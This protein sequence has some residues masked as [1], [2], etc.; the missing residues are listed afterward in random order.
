[1]SQTDS[2][3][4]SD[5]TVVESSQHGSG[6]AD[7]V[8]LN[9]QTNADSEILR[10]SDRTT[11][12]SL[13]ARENR[14]VELNASLIKRLSD[15]S[16]STDAIL[17]SIQNLDT[18]DKIAEQG[19]VLDRGYND[20]VQLYDE[21]VEV[22]ENKVDASIET[23]STEY[24]TEVEFVKAELAKK[25]EELVILQEEEENA[26]RQL[27]AAKKEYAEQ[28]RLYEE[29]RRRRLERRQS[30]KY[31]PDQQS[32]TGSSP[33]PPISPTP[34][35]NITLAQ[36]AVSPELPT[37]SACPASSMSVRSYDETNVEVVKAI[38]EN[39]ATT[40]SKIRP[41]KSVKPDVFSGNELE[42]LHWEID[43]EAYLKAEDIEGHERLRHLK[44]FTEGEAR[45]CIE[46]YFS[47]NSNKAYLDARAKLKSRYGNKQNVARSF[48]RKLA[49]W[50]K[51]TTKDEKSL[52]EFSD[53]LSHIQSNM[54]AI[55]S[56][57][58]LN[59]CS[60][61]EKMVAKLPDWLRNRWARKVA[62]S[63]DDVDEYPDLRKFVDFLEEEARIMKLP[64]SQISQ[65]KESTSKISGNKERPVR[66][67]LATASGTTN[68]RNNESAISSDCLFCHQNNHRTGNCYQLKSLPH[69]KRVQFVTENGLC[70]SC[71]RKGHMSRACTKKLQCKVCNKYHPTA[72]HYGYSEVDQNKKP[73]S[74][75]LSQKPETKEVKSNSTKKTQAG[76]LSMTIPV[77]ISPANGGQE[78]LIYALLDTQSDASFISKEV[79]NGLK[80]IRHTTEKIVLSTLNGKSTQTVNRYGGVKIRG[81]NATDVITLAAYE[82]DTL[83]CERSQ[84][85]CEGDAVK[86]QHLKP[87]AS[88]LGQRLNIPVGLLIGADCPE[89][90]APLET[91]VGAPGEPFAI[92]TTL[93]W[94]LCGGKEKTQQHRSLMTDIC[95]TDEDE[96]SQTKVSQ[97][98][99]RFID[100]LEKN[101]TRDENGNYQMPLP[102][103]ERPSLPNNY[104]QAEKRLEGLKRKFKKDHAYKTEYTKFMDDLI[105][106][107]QAE[108]V[109]EEDEV[110]GEVWYLPHFGIYHPKKRKI[111]VVYDCAAK[112]QDTALNDHL[113]Q[114][115]D[116]MNN[117]VGMLCRFRKED[118]AITCDIEKMFYNFLVSPGDRNFLRFLWLDSEGQTRIYRMKVHLFGA[119]SSPGVATY[120]LRKL[121]ANNAHISEDAAAFIQ[122][123]FYVDD[124]VTSVGDAAEAKKLIEDA[125]EICSQ[126]NVRLH[127]FLSNNR[128][129]L[130]SI[131]ESER[132]AKPDESLPVQRTLGMEWDAEIDKFKFS[133]TAATG[134][135]DTK[136]QILSTVSKIY[137]PLG[138]V[139]PYVLQGKMVLQKIVSEKLDWDER[140]SDQQQ[141]EWNAW[142]K[143]LP[144]LDTIL[145]DRCIKPPG[146]GEIIRKELHHFCDASE[147]GMGACSYIRLMNDRGQVHCNLIL[148][149]SRV[150]PLKPTTIPRLE[151]QAAVLATRLSRAIHQE[152]GM[153]IDDEFYWS[154]SKIALGYIGNDAKR[155]HTYVANRVYEIR[156]WSRAE[157]WHHIETTLNP[158]D[159]ASRGG[160]V[161]QL[162]DSSWWVGPTFLWKQ[163]LDIPSISCKNQD[164]ECNLNDN[165]PEIRKVRANTTTSK[166]VPTMGNRF[167]RYSDWMKLSKAIAQM[168]SIAASGEW[169]IRPIG[170]SEVSAAERFII[171][172]VQHEAFGV[173]MEAL[174]QNQRVAK[175][176]S[177]IK[178][179]PFLDSDGILRIGG[180]CDASVLLT[181][182]EKHPIILPK[183]SH[184]STLI[185]QYFHKQT[186]HQGRTTTLASLR[187]NGYWIL[188]A[189]QLIKTMVRKCVVCQKLRGEPVQQQMGALPKERLEPSPPFTFVG[190][191]TF[192]PFI[193]KDRRT[194]IKRWG[195]IFTC[196]YTRAV[197][198]E[199]ADD[200]TSD[201]FIN[202]LRNL[203][204]IRGP[205]NCLFSD[206]GT[207]FIGAHNEMEV[208]LDMVTDPQLR[209][210]LCAKKIEFRTNPPEA[211]HQGGIWERPIRTT[212][213][214]L[215]GM[216]D[217]YKGR[218]DTSTL[219]TALYE[220][221]A[222]VNSR[223]LS[224][225]NINDPNEMVLTP[226]HLLTMKTGQ[227]VSPGEFDSTE[228]YGRKR[229]RKAQQF[230]SEFWTVWKSQYLS[231]VTKRQRW[232]QKEGNI[233]VDDVVLVV[234][235]S[236]P[237]SCW[238]VGIV[239]S[240][241]RGKDGLVRSAVIRLAGKG[242]NG[243]TTL[244]RPV[245]KLIVLVNAENHV[246][247]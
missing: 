95:K 18:V 2:D 167:A 173:E 16:D 240:L 74:T 177:L 197:H 116:Q 192:G 22:S 10:R 165:D 227:T 14:T 162:K 190:M 201:C 103:K 233:S 102:F 187:G 135:L 28:L 41:R 230:A 195:I 232:E 122:S 206:N 62:K 6:G 156:A 172:V 214:V 64:V 212:R 47:A 9:T 139:A 61:N 155:F 178:F 3:S 239:N 30:I 131:P 136:R 134:Q 245:Q 94:T 93:G 198:L 80:D 92:K 117:L 238:Q 86:W 234:E 35:H 194:E 137:D 25:R 27:E 152:L 123:D 184:V 205:V 202:A 211:S 166:T 168:K 70:Y 180:R 29:K 19:E 246:T 79:A 1:M 130:D 104:Q 242:L 164:T 225:E 75:E 222:I 132:C 87:I 46:G 112:F 21:L 65:K 32:S 34:D 8:E 120:G 128:E 42:F 56:L 89:A 142:L 161:Q 83:N 154:D 133:F 185:A 88:H 141:Q 203:T 182:K 183:T 124:G 91:L 153:E 140:I 149:K 60:E 114:G 224:I 228:I 226:N 208:A 23:M 231:S 121:A 58:I 66:S 220:V 158:A 31:I 53:F 67:Y 235:N 107:G 237:R 196:L 241:N 106:N 176:S 73:E 148:A 189:N 216:A 57:N 63:L 38:T 40:I 179:D 97:E 17:A 96:F 37:Q 39:L 219:R 54:E 247:Q 52:Q 191:D 127:K 109:T 144:Q 7:G 159:I 105:Q 77:Y 146:F 207:N 129:V 43:L 33:A 78:K 110:P 84:I 82:Q 174:Q 100:I 160:S 108:P 118:I 59:D 98:D 119:T 171:K 113:M 236:K 181:Y 12:L 175:G 210:F 50:P 213:S 217:K 150:A 151:L 209:E 143:Q 138:F 49:D 145:I 169:K 147:R 218:W 69:Q 188:G 215:N 24:K 44:R 244:E 204:A 5:V 76:I 125:R 55:P 199:V 11:T 229:W 243:T 48:K 51:V 15:L 13:R 115:P 101:T 126:G 85:P 68:S 71:M 4:M 157:Q 99:L 36:P 223:P 72:M 200:M 90:L 193:V 45:K 111:R 81:M 26:N 20:V 221:M 163:N 170:L 186:F